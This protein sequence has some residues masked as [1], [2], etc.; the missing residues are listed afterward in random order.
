MAG[1]WKIMEVHLCCPTLRKSINW[2]PRID[3]KVKVIDLNKFY[4]S[5]GNCFS[6]TFQFK[7]AIPICGFGRCHGSWT[8]SNWWNAWHV[9]NTHVDW[10]GAWL[11]FFIMRKSKMLDKRRIDETQGFDLIKLNFFL[12]V[13]FVTVVTRTPDSRFL[14]PPYR[15][16]KTSSNCNFTRSHSTDINYIHCIINDR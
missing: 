6:Q 4:W 13:F 16:R 11:T 1:E 10:N 8:I 2:S 14:W 15:R 12:I 9:V 5:T 3:K 7:E